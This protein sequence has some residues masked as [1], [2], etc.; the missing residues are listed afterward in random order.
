MPR[1]YFV[2]VLMN[3]WRTTSYI[4][5]TSNLARRIT[6][7]REKVVEGFTKRYHLTMLVYYETFPTAYEAISREKQLKRWSREKKI[8]LIHSTNPDLKD[9]SDDLA[10]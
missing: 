2:Y 4:G 7:H 5:V 3:R 6:Q 10:L 8:T 9:L 1:Q